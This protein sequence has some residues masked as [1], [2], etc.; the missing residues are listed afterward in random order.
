[1]ARKKDIKKGLTVWSNV[2]ITGTKKLD[3]KADIGNFMICDGRVI[4]DEAGIEYN[5]RD[6]KK[7]TDK[8]LYFL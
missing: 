4:I 1:M 6:F 8:A 3:P 7:F 2:P 5:N